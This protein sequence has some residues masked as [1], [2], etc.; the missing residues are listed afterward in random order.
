MD[1][2]GAEVR[3]TSAPKPTCAAVARRSTTSSDR[4][5]VGSLAFDSISTPLCS[6]ENWTNP[7]GGRSVARVPPAGGKT[8]PPSARSTTVDGWKD[9]TEGTVKG[10]VTRGGGW[11]FRLCYGLYRRRKSAGAVCYQVSGR[12]ALRTSPRKRVVA[13]AISP[14]RLTRCSRPS[15]HPLQMRVSTESEET[16]GIDDAPAVAVAAQAG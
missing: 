1:T 14:P 9:I 5:L 6:P 7:G 13:R 11:S 15:W 10:H 2:L 12:Q 16:F 8:V 4:V 3:L